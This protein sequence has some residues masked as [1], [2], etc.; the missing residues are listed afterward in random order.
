M[1]IDTNAQI[2][3][4]HRPHVTVVVFS[5]VLCHERIL[6]DRQ[7][8]TYDGSPSIW[9]PKSLLKKMLVNLPK[10]AP[11]P[12]LPWDDNVPLTVPQLL[13]AI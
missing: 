10:W 2:K 5:Y 6:E 8:H 4:C 13:S 12:N 11:L 9:D 3:I 1:R 7:R